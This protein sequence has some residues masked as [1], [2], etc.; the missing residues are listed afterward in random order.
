M[1]GGKSWT[2]LKGAGYRV[3]CIDQKLVNGV[4][5]VWNHI[6][7]G[8]ED[9]TGD[10]PIEECVRWLRHAEFFVGLSSGLAWPAWAAGARVVMISGFSLPNTEFD[11]PWRVI[12]YHACVGCW[13]DP[14][15][16]FNHRDFCGALAMPARRASSNAPSLITAEQVKQTIR[17]IPGFVG[18]SVSEKA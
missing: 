8:A 2:F 16:R 9:K 3:I 5:I 4:G 17:R 13:N 1:A 7:A 12:N 11:T 10:M 6:P 18:E 14:T 15:L